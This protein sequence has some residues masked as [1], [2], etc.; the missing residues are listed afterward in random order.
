[1]T[2]IQA[3]SGVFEDRVNCKPHLEKIWYLLQIHI[4]TVT[5]YKRKSSHK[6]YLLRIDEILKKKESFQQRP[7]GTSNW[8]YNL[9][10]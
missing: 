3:L 1:M 6:S 7:A 10:P 4:S 8:L 9:K 2:F 5:K